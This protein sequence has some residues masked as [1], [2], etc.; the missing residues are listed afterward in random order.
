[1]LSIH[2]SQCG[3]LQLRSAVVR[4]HSDCAPAFVLWSGR[5]RDATRQTPQATFVPALLTRRPSLSV[6]S[7]RSLA[8]ASAAA[9]A[10]PRRVRSM[11]SYSMPAGS[12][13]R[14]TT[15]RSIRRSFSHAYF[16]RTAEN[17]MS[18]YPVLRSVLCCFRGCRC[19]CC[20]D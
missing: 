10:V 12:G 2:G 11:S 3:C 9:A 1:M 8:A 13:L 17:N 5:C 19:C 7:L 4:C 14:L 15:K 6:T 18:R 16:D 20:G